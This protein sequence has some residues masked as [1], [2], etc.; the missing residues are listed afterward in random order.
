M[1]STAFIAAAPA[2]SSEVPSKWPTH[3]RRVLAQ[4]RTQIMH[5][6]ASSLPTKA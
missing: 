1:P 6:V 4:R 2:P 5:V 3:V